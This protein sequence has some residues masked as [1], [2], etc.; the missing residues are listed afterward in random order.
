VFCSTTHLQ[1]LFIST[2][3]T[4]NFPNVSLLSVQSYSVGNKLGDTLCTFD[5]V[6]EAAIDGNDDGCMVGTG[7]GSTDDLIETVG[8]YDGKKVGLAEEVGTRLGL[9]IGFDD[10]LGCI[11]GPNVA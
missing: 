9:P 11:D 5:G 2:S 3:G 4:K 10:T 8:L 1:D 6:T 7:L